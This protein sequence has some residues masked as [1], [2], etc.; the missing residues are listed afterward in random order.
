MS[1]ILRLNALVIVITLLSSSAVAQLGGN[2]TYESLNLVT[3]ARSMGLGGV[4]LAIKDDDLD[5]AWYNPSLLNETMH[6]HLVLNF[7]DYLSDIKIVSSNYSYTHEKFGSL[8][9]GIQYIYFGNFQEYDETGMFLR[10]FNAQDIVFN[11]GWGK[12]VAPKINL[13][14]ENE[15]TLDSM[16]YIGANFKFINSAYHFDYSSF[17]V[18]VDLAGTYHN[19]KKQMVVALVIKNIGVQI[20]PYTEGNREPLPFEIQAGITKKLL[21]APFRLMLHAQHLEKWNLTYENP[22]TFVNSLDSSQMDTTT[23]QKIGTNVTGFTDKLLR[24]AVFGTEMVITKNFHIRLGYNYQKRKELK[25]V[26]KKGMAG[27]SIG[28]GLKISKFNF[29]YSRSSFHLAGGSNQFSVRTS[30][31]EFKSKSKDPEEI[32]ELN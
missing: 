6:N 8:S 1:L 3:S 25:S 10:E 30:L 31:S 19:R 9:A 16:F 7:V 23:F 22:N 18:A 24:H 15:R 27:F 32:P 14:E 17:G 4:V 20:K 21:H 29:S 2:N 12:A 13:G 26:T 5:L 28:V 11:L